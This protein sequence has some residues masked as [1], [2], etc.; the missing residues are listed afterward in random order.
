MP[1]AVR[2]GVNAAAATGGGCAAYC[3]L[4]V[5]LL[6]RLGGDSGLGSGTLSAARRVATIGI[7]TLRRMRPLARGLKLC[8]QE[9]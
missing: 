6:V 9:Q 7:A 1:G 5:W 3:S 2:S 4:R 8:T